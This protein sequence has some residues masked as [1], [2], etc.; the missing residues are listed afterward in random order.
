MPAP[1][2][3]GSGGLTSLETRLIEQYVSV[4]DYVSRCAQAI[5]GG[6]WHYLGDKAHA[7]AHA[8]ARLDQV[9]DEALAAARQ[10]RGP[11]PETVGRGVAVHGRHYRAARLLHPDQP[12]QGGAAP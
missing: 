12:R 8:A 5:D 6:N 10:R 11:R 2:S 1:S 4:L 7:L 3:Q 9:A